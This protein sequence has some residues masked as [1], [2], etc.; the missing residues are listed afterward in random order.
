M[1]LFVGVDIV[2][3]SDFIF[4]RFFLNELTLQDL[5]FVL[6]VAN[7][8]D[9]I[10][11]KEVVEEPYPAPDLVTLT[12]TILPVELVSATTSA[13]VPIPVIFISGVEL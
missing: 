3:S 6:K 1:S 5:I 10:T 4:A 2:T 13:P 8:P 11:S 12:D 7:F 9:L